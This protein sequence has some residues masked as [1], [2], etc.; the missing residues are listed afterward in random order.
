M[1]LPVLVA[2]AILAILF[3]IVIAG[4]PDEFNLMRSARI[5]APPEK[6]FPHVNS[7]RAWDAWSPW[8]RLDPDAKNSFEGPEAGVGSVMSWSG[9]RKIGAGRMTITESRANERVGFSLEFLKP[10]KATNTAEFVFRRNGN[11]TEVVWSMSGKSNFFF[12]VFGLFV[13]CDKM[14]GKDFEKGLAQMK[15]LV[16]AATGK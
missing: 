6:I 12:K 2:A 8:A 14:A 4:Q 10:F 5:S 9:N 11:Q 16:E 7:L 1:L 3:L 13:D 15:S